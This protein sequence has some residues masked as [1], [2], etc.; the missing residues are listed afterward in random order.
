VIWLGIETSCDETAAAV[1]ENGRIVHSHIVRSQIPFHQAWGGVVPE[2]AARRHLEWLPEIVTAARTQSGCSWDTIEGVCATQGPGLATALLVGFQAAKALACRL[3]VPFA[4]IHHLEGHLVSPFLTPER[5][6]FADHCPLT[7][8]IVSGGHTMLVKVARPGHYQVVGTTLDDAAGEAFDKG[9]KLLGLPYP[10]GPALEK[11]AQGGNPTAVRFP[12]AY[13]ANRPTCFSFSGL[14]TALLYHLRHHPEA[15]SSPAVRADIAA[16]YQ[17]AI[18]EVLVT[19]TMEVA[20]PHRPLAVVG[21]VSLNSRL[22]KRMAEACAERG[23]PLLLA[24]PAYCG[25]NAAM[26]AA[27]AGLG[28][29]RHGNDALNADCD[30]QLPLPPPMGAL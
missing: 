30:P 16:S 18:V 3:E 4:A 14:K 12:R 26:I 28:L 25:D 10:G 19:R 2:M 24:E 27:A 22:R 6:T 20:D 15:L 8:L 17:E 13:I 5:P 1:V 29:G 7:A 11:A 21:G 23:I 9:A